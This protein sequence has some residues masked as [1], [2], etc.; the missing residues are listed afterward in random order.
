MVRWSASQA[1]PEDPERAK[2]RAEE[3]EAYVDA[4]PGKLS[5][6]GSGLGFGAAGVRE[7]TVRSFKGRHP[8]PRTF[9]ALPAVVVVPLAALL[10]VLSS[11]IGFFVFALVMGII[12]I[13]DQTDAPLGIGLTAAIWAPIVGVWVGKNILGARKGNQAEGNAASSDPPTSA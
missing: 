2:E 12:F 7:W 8:R 6:L 9:P 4:I 10:F 13:L 11:I 1:F 5:K 3:L